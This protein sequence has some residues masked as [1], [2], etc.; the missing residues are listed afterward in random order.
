MSL[1]TI[2]ESTFLLTELRYTLGQ[3]AV[4]TMGLDSETRQ[5]PLCSG[6]SV[7]QILSEMIDR[8]TGFQKSCAELLGT[9][10]PVASDNV[11]AAIP[12]SS[13]DVGASAVH[14]FEQLRTATIELLEGHDSW[15]P[16][17]LADVKE[18]AAADRR[19]TTA[20]AECR[21]AYLDA[22]HGEHLQKPLTTPSEDPSA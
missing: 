14:R 1:E 9:T 13:E 19:E 10:P 22:T 20:I 5:M 16:A 3:L 7:D 11:G 8:E 21:R 2:S 18:Q 15:P 12:L 17:L 4:Q 6:R